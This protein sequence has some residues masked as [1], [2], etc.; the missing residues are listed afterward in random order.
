MLQL[1]LVLLSTAARGDALAP[2]YW[3]QRPEVN[4]PATCDSGWC[5]ASFC[6]A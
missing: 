2:N 4:P 3:L 1:R 6:V 5:S